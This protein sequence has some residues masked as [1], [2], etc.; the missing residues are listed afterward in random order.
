MILEK[1]HCSLLALKMHFN[2]NLRYTVCTSVGTCEVTN[3][4]IIGSVS[5]KTYLATIFNQGR[6]L[7]RNL[8]LV[9]LYN[10]EIS[11]RSANFMICKLVQFEVHISHVL[12]LAFM[13]GYSCS[14]RRV[15]HLKKVRPLCKRASVESETLLFVRHL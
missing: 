3:Y 11:S 15:F 10:S 4:L 9:F 8:L 13:C 6:I 7:A 1:Q 12:R 2:C 14:K 5:L